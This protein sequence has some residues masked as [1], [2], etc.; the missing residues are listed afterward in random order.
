[1]GNR[2]ENPRQSAS[3]GHHNNMI[4]LKVQP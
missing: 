3:A 1:M 2:L 4:G